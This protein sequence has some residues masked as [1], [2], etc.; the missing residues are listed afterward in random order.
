M[1]THI[2]FHTVVDRHCFAHRYLV[3]QQVGHVP[4]GVV[5][6]I[7]VRVVQNRRHQR[8]AAGAA[9]GEL[10]GPVGQAAGVGAIFS[11]QCIL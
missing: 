11:A 10:A 8:A 1:D 3:V 5:A 2:N 7:R 4:K 6:F 9:V